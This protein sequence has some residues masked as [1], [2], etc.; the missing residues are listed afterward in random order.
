MKK[1]VFILAACAFVFALASEA[2]AAGSEKKA[3]PGKVAKEKF[4]VLWIAV[5]KKQGLDAIKAAAKELA[6]AQRL[7]GPRGE[8][9]NNA[10]YV[11][12]WRACVDVIDRAIAADSEREAWS[13]QR[14]IGSSCM[15][16]HNVYNKHK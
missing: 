13:A 12:K 2:R 8:M 14:R 6:E 11:S 10:D 7:H 4:K 9:A 16:C 5:K 15:A 1:M 3:S